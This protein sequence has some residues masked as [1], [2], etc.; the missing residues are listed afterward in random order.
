MWIGGLLF[1]AGAI[2]FFVPVAPRA[3]GSPE[4]AEIPVRRPTAAKRG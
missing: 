4:R 2:A 1:L 3:A